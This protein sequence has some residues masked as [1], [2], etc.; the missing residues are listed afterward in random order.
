MAAQAQAMSGSRAATGKVS[1]KT[2]FDDNY[3]LTVKLQNC[4]PA[5]G[6]RAGWYTCSS[7]ITDWC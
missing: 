1:S 3:G 7:P 4:P 2:D 6:H 5:G